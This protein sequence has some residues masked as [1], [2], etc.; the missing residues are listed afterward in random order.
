MRRRAAEMRVAE[1]R[2]VCFPGMNR[3]EK[4]PPG[5]ETL[6]PGSAWM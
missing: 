6:F 5:S 1:D 4:T 3:P 2:S